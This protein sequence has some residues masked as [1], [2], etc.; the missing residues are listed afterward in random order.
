MSKVI[1]V[2]HNL[3]HWEELEDLAQNLTKADKSKRTPLSGGTKGEEDVVGISTISQCKY[4]ETKSI[5]M[6][7]RDITRLQSAAALH[8]KLPLFW[9]ANSTH[10]VVSLLLDGQDDEIVKSLINIAIVAKGA[11]KHKK[12]MKHIKTMRELS[13]MRREVTRLRQILTLEVDKIKDSLSSI[14]RSCD[15]K[16]DDLT[17]I[18]LFEGVEGEKNG[19]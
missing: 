16:Y 14:S 2:G 5:S 7:E 19:S 8:N 15:A 11:E 18:D 17:M 9:S 3:R 12:T 4:T 1:A 6:L 10:L 13:I